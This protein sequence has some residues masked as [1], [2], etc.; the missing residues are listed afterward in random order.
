MFA[1][2]FRLAWL[3]VKKTPVLS[4]L[5]VCAIGLGIGVCISILTVFALMTSDPAPEISAQVYTYKLQNQEILP[6]GSDG[7][8]PSNMV[9]YRDV[10]NLQAFDL[11]IRQSI[12]YQ[13]AAVI[14]PEGSGQT[15]FTDEVRLANTGFFSLH[16]VPFRY[17]G[18]WSAEEEASGLYQTVLT[19]DLNEKLFGGNNS[20]GEKVRIGNWLFD[21]VGVLDEFKPT[22]LYFE[23]DGGAFREMTGAILPFALTKELE[24]RKR[25]GSTICSGDPEGEGWLN[26]LEAD[27]QWIHHWVEI[28]DAQGEQA[29]RDHLDNYAEA[30]RQRGRFLGPYNNEVHSLKSWLVDQR[31]VDQDYRI[32]LAVA[33]LFLL[34]CLLNCI[35]LL[36]A[37]FLG[38][39]GEMSLR[40]AVGGSR[41]MIFR[42]H[43]VEISLIGLLGGLVG[44]LLAMLGLVAIRSLYQ[45]FELLT[46]LNIELALLAVLLAMA[47]TVLAGIYPAWRICRLPIALHLK[48]Q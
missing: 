48:A 4:S 40:R 17:G 28:T 11:P 46:H 39:A 20:V 7:D 42:Q 33:F 6:G 30:Q 26:Y 31:V 24:L 43:L 9:G 15:P 5:I 3:S 32:L 12:H 23:L 21:V 35:G 1:Y 16:R 36:L 45:N 8:E 41:K 25:N 13:S 38:R 29:Y 37:K 10:I 2:H 14:Y 27:C 18:H 19:R 47:S 34:V 22:P 44:L